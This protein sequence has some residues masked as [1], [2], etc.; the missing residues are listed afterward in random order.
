MEVRFLDV[1]LVGSTLS[2]VRWKALLQYSGRN[3]PH[4]VDAGGTSC[5]D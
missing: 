3:I 4:D 5:W 2:H 1:T